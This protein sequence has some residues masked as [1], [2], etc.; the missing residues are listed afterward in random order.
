MNEKQQMELKYKNLGAHRVA[1]LKMAKFP[2]ADEIVRSGLLSQP[3]G[4]DAV[5]VLLV[6]PH[7]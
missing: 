3:R 6:N 2:N 7:P 4:K 5:D 1:P